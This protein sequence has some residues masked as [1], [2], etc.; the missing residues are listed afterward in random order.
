MMGEIPLN[1]RTINFIMLLRKKG[2]ITKK[3]AG[4]GFMS[5]YS[6]IWKL[7]DV[8]LVYENGIDKS[9]QKIWSLTNKGERLA[10]L[11]DNIRGL[12]KDES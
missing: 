2:G 7:R 11:L 4:M 10:G 12:M 5:Y 6:L 9:N 8:G 1:E 3:N